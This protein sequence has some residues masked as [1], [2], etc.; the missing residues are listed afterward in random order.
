MSYFA[1]HCARKQTNLHASKV[2][3]SHGLE[4]LRK[5][6]IIRRK[7][8][9][10]KKLFA[11]VFGAL[12]VL[13]LSLPVMAQDTTQS[14][15]TTTTQTPDRPQTQ[16]TQTNESTTKYKHHHKKVKKE[17]Q[18]TTTTTTPPQREHSETTTTTT[19]PPPQ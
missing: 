3:F 14:T 6:G 10:S 12:V 11:V 4:S 7:W 18:T 8:M 19:R 2:A 1:Q 17:K 13:A 5:L 16:T 9:K 15:T